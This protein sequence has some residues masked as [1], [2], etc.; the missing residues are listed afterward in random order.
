MVKKAHQHTTLPSPFKIEVGP[1]WARR[2]R[3]K[4]THT[5]HALLAMVAKVCDLVDAAEHV[6]KHIDALAAEHGI[7]MSCDS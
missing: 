3:D 2:E 1:R 4:T 5:E 6:F 7:R